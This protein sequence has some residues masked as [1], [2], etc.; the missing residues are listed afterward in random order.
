MTAAAVGRDF[1]RSLFPFD[2]FE[3]HV[4]AGLIQTLVQIQFLVGT[5]VSSS[6]STFA[7]FKSQVS[8]PSVNQL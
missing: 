4:T 2:K 3:R 8:N 7:S 6:S 5:T 1:D